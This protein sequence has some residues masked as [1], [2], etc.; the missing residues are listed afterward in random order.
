MLCNGA[1]TFSQ[2]LLSTWKADPCLSCNA[3][4]TSINPQRVEPKCP[5]FLVLGALSSVHEVLH[6]HP[7]VLVLGALSS[8]HEVLH[9][10]RHIWACL[11]VNRMNKRTGVLPPILPPPP[12]N[13]RLHESHRGT[14]H[15]AGVCMQ[16]AGGGGGGGGGG[17]VST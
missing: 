10:H 14:V 15:G 2:G 16:V 5:G 8:V 4:T 9:E 6:E 3:S 17:A 7:S 11:P 13:T 12:P 1:E